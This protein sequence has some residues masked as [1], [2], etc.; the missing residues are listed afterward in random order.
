MPR[1]SSRSVAPLSGHTTVAVNNGGCARCGA[2]LRLNLGALGLSRRV[3]AGATYRMGVFTA[4]SSSFHPF[5]LP[6]S[7]PAPP[8]VAPDFAAMG[9]GPPIWQSV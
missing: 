9:G 8:G 1:D 5:T 6:G 3:C 4:N 7:P 2:E